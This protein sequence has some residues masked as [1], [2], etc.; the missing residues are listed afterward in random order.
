MLVEPSPRQ[1]EDAINRRTAGAAVAEAVGVHPAA[2]ELEGMLGLSEEIAALP[3]QASAAGARERVRDH[4]I[5]G[6]RAHRAA[7][8]HRHDLPMRRAKHPQPT[9]GIRWSLVVGIAVM[10][11][12]VAGLTLALASQLAEPDGSLY[13]LKLNSERLLVAINRSPLSKAGVHMQLANQRYRDTEA[14]A[15]R[16]KG[17]LAVGTMQSYYDQL[18]LAAADLES[19]K[20]D[21]SWKSLRSQFSTAE[22][23]SINEIQ[24][25]LRNT[26]QTDALTKITAIADQFAKD[27]KD[28]DARLS[29]T[30]QP[31]GVQPSP[32]PSGAQPQ[33]GGVNP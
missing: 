8:V 27:R 24:V 4:F 21:A 11:A 33:P 5:E 22:S 25:Q 3:T 26:K 23:K 16:G 17:E 10:L 29:T 28:I 7:W 32:L 14:M 31:G 6:G 2:E 1:L 12:L 13:P 19:A 18:R 30:A 20:R 9:H 15:A